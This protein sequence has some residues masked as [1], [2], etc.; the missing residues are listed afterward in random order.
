MS[1]ALSPA[2]ID[3]LRAEH[4][5]AR[6]RR[7]THGFH[8]GGAAG[9]DRNHQRSHIDAA[10]GP[11]QLARA[12]RAVTCASHLRQMGHALTMYVNDWKYYPGCDVSRAG[13]KVAV[14][15]LR[16]RAYLTGARTSSTARCAT[17]A[18][19][20]AIPAAQATARPTPTR[21][22][23]TGT[24]KPC[25]RSKRP[26]LTATTRGCATGVVFS[27]ALNP[28]GYR[29]GHGLGGD[30]SPVTPDRSC[31]QLKYTV[32]RDADD[33][34]AIA[35]NTGG[36]PF[37]FSI[38]PNQADQYPGAVHSGGCNVLFCD[39][40]VSWYLPGDVTLPLGARTPNA[41]AIAQMWNNDHGSELRVA[42]PH[43]SRSPAASF[44]GVQTPPNRADLK[45]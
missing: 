33:M 42:V 23:D 3:K 21:A 36:G 27:T 39:G 40:H 8:P 19:D 2:P 32:V 7:R 22:G 12:A 10:A 15:P 13:G 38:Q 43:R 31:Y 24:A 11:E 20:G 17:R 41:S 26:S 44:A 1:I 4:D 25:F 34:I 6:G 35:D 29:N 30:L 14:W 37:N 18:G 5:F 28:A 16:L 45:A 9:G